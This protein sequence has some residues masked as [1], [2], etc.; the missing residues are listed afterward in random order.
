[1]TGI[2]KP[3]YRIFR[4][5]QQNDGYILDHRHANDRYLLCRAY[6]VIE[7]DLLKLFQYIEPSDKNKNTFSQRTYELLL[8]AATEFETN[9]KQILRANG[10]EASKNKWDMNDYKKIDKATKLSEYQIK[11]NIWYPDGK[12]FQ[13]LAPWK[14]S[15]PLE[16]YQDYNHVKHDRFKN[17]KKAKLINVVNAISAVWAVLYAQFSYYIFEPYNDSIGLTGDD[18]DWE[19]SD[20]TLF[21]IKPFNAWPEEDAYRFEWPN[22]NKSPFQKFKF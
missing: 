18:P 11:L 1:M 10:Y 7:D 5:K 9:C 17:F 8:R 15:R 3:Y 6:R 19:Y 12:V 16:W 2:K 13:P 4:A 20:S 21:S 22:K 14:D